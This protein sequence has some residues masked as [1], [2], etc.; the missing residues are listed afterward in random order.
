[1]KRGTWQDICKGSTFAAEPPSGRPP[2]TPNPRAF[3]FALLERDG[4]MAN[5]TTK[6]GL[7]AG[8]KGDVGEP[9]WKARR[10]RNGRWQDPAL[11]ADKILE[12]AFVVVSVKLRRA[13]AEEFRAVC[14][15]IGVRPNRAFRA[16]ARHAAGYVELGSGTDDDLR[17]IVRQ[18][19]GIAVNVNQIAKSANTTRSPDYA[20]LMDE[21]K[22]LGP[23]LLRIQSRTRE[24]LDSATRRF[25]GRERLQLAVD[26]MDDDLI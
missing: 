21:R 23:I 7:V 15:E 2:R 22:R 16:M 3:P 19:R 5:Q 6:E 4:R 25:D 24:I 12:P 9:A 18:L 13:E 14:E 11:S 1:M 26:R 8:A 17:E 10:L 20:E